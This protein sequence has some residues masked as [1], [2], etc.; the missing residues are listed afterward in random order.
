M[1]NPKLRSTVDDGSDRV[2]MKTSTLSKLKIEKYDHIS[3][4]GRSLC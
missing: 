2:N 3:S 1:T 4:N